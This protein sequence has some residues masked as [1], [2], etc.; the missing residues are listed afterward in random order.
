MLYPDGA[1]S[2]PDGIWYHVTEGGWV[3]SDVVTSP[4]SSSA[5]ND[6][7]YTPTNDTFSSTPTYNTNIDEMFTLSKKGSS[8][9]NNFTLK[10]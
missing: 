7:Q 1:K 5:S 9:T 6:T 3:R 8:V 2:M 4:D 10:R